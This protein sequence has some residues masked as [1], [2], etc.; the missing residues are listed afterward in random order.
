MRLINVTTSELEDFSGKA[1]PPYAILSHRWEQSEATFQT[2]TRRH[3]RKDPGITKILSFCE[4][5]KS[6]HPRLHYGW[7]DTCCIDK[8]NNAELTEAMYMWYARAEICYVY[9]MDLL[10]KEQG[11]HKERRQAF[12]ESV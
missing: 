2:Y 5:I 8:H 3:L 9:L 11:N 7:V 4:L 10:T 1:L 6:R 12:V